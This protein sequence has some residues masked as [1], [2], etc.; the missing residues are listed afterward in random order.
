MVSGQK[1]AIVRLLQDNDPETVRLV[2]EQLASA[3]L[4]AIGALTALAEIEDE[5]VSQHVREVLDLIVDREPRT[6]SRCSAICSAITT[7]SS[8]RTGCSPARCCRE[9]ISPRSRRR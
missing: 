5:R 1:D 4:E 6:S 7:I 3:G 2:K 9:S 8:A